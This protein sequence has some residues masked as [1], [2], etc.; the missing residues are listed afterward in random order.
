MSQLFVQPLVPAL[1]LQGLP[2]GAATLSF[3]LTGTLTPAI[4]YGDMALTV[5]LGTV[6]TA[7]A[8]GRFVSI[9]LD[10]AVQ[11]RVIM[12]DHVGAALGDV[13][14]GSDSTSTLAPKNN[15]TFTGNVVVPTN[16]ITDNSTKAVNSEWVRGL[17]LAFQAT[18]GLSFAAS[19]AI[20]VAELGGWGMFAAAS[21]TMTMPSISAETQGQTMAF[22]G[23][24]F[25]GTVAGTGSENITNSLGQTANT[26]TVAPGEIAVLTNDGASGWF[27]TIGGA[28]YSAIPIGN[29]TKL[30]AST[31][32]TTA[33]TV[34]VTAATIPLAGPNGAVFVDRNVSMT[35]NSLAT[36]AGG[37]D[38]GALA[39]STW[40][41]VHRIYNPATGVR[42][43]LL[44]LSAT[45][46]TLPSGYTFS[47]CVHVVRTDAAGTK[48][49]LPMMRNGRRVQYQPNGGAGRLMATG[50]AG[51]PN[52]PT[53]V[54]VALA[55]FVPSQAVFISG[56]LNG[57]SGAGASAG[58]VAPN[59]SYG[60]I[61][62][63]TNPPP[64]SVL[65]P[66]SYYSVFQSEFCFMIESANIY[67]ATSSSY[68]LFCLGWEDE[69]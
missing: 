33:T 12:R 17:G 34:S 1:N 23:G 11:Y 27:V 19:G 32:G 59:N 5:P 38:T 2:S 4:V 57:Y 29:P 42:S 31:T 21:V 30:V 36:G 26:L 8:Y 24:T 18:S 62:S 22:V 28:P 63:T 9:Y 16:A 69:L 43:G 3:Y 54:A 37:L 13:E 53:W 48:Y 65:I 44:S 41:Y 7:D 58:A 49:L 45:A 66:V 55:N 14:L 40:Y 39:G 25:G 51:D 6:V 35:V 50:S 15:P 52:T 64:V 20:T 61:S 10:G 46:P 67:W 56:I 60:G 47:R 68:T